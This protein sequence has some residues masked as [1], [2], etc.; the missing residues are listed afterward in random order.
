MPI[1][2]VP[3]SEVH[4]AFLW[5]MLYLAI[6]VHKGQAPYPR[7]IIQK[8]ELSIYASHYKAISLS[9][10]LENPAKR[11]YQRAGFIPYARENHSLTMIKYL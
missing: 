10:D 6:Y 7:E 11:L 4:Q 9:V 5:D 3:I 8:P 1:K 2:M